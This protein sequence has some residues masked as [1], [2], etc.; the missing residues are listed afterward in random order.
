M[1]RRGKIQIRHSPRRKQPWHYVLL[2]G[3][4]EVMVTS[5]NFSSRADCKRRVVRFL[6]VT[7]QDMDIEEV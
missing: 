1:S 3:N 2:G 7:S 6:N 4:G 5:E